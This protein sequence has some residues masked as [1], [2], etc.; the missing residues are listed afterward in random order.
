MSFDPHKIPFYRWDYQEGTDSPESYR[1]YIAELALSDWC[2][3]SC[4]ESWACSP[5]ALLNEAVT[6][7]HF[8]HLFKEAHDNLRDSAVWR[9]RQ[10]MAGKNIQ[11]QWNIL[12]KLF[13]RWHTPIC[14]RLVMSSNASQLYPLWGG[15]SP[16]LLKVWPAD[17]RE[18]IRNAEPWP[19]LDLQS[20]L[21][22]SPGKWH[23]L[24]RV[25][26][27]PFQSPPGHTGLS[28][29]CGGR[30]SITYLTGQVDVCPGFF[31]LILSTKAVLSPKTR[32]LNSDA[33]PGS[34]SP[35]P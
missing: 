5:E 19:T 12:R 27:T 30:I 18:R 33:F 32:W 2:L 34:C 22:T 10:G 29:C 21:T 8:A 9:V 3:H 6:L 31:S 16:L 28:Q 25:C 1:C 7:P 15:S 35:L 14:S 23:T 13:P 24:V 11:S 17:T 20:I 26:G 4:L